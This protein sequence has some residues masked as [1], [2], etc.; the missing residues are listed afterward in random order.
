MRTRHHLRLPVLAALFATL[1]LPTG[2][3]AAPANDDFAGATPIASLPFDTT[4]ST[5]GATMETTEPR[6]TCDYVAAGASVWHRFAPEAAGVVR[7]ST[8]GSDYDTVLAVYTQFEGTFSAVACNDQAEADSDAAAVRFEATGGTTYFLQTSGH[9]AQTGLL[10]LHVEI[11]MPADPAPVIVPPV[12]CESCGFISYE[13]PSEFGYR[14]GETS[15]GIN[16]RTNTAMFLL[17]T[18]VMRVRWDDTQSPPS[19]RWEDVT[20]LISGIDT[21]DPILWTDPSTGRTFVVQLHA[22]YG[23]TIEYTDDDGETWTMGEPATVMPSF[24]HQSLGGGPSMLPVANP[25]YPNTLYYCAQSGIS[26]CARS[27]DG[28]RTWGAPLPMNV[29]L[30]GGLHGHIVVAPDGTVYVPHR[31]CGNAAAVMVSTNGG[32]TW[33]PRPVPSTLPSPSD[34]AVASDSAGRLYFVASSEGRALV[35]TTTDRGAH[36]SAPID[37]GA[38]FGIH[39]VEQPM[40]VAG[41]AG[42]A[43]VAFYG[44]REAGNDQSAGYRGVWHL[45]L[46]TTFDG[47]E[48]WVTTD[49]TPNDPVQRGCIWMGGGENPCRNLLDFQGM[50]V[51]ANGRIIIG[52]ADGCVTERCIGPDGNPL[53]SRDSRGTIARQINGPRLLDSE[54]SV[55][56]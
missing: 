19:A 21:N 35:S 50:T 26:Q 9:D 31:D 18:R 34:P 14:A 42:R 4:E 47:G 55:E 15:I 38:A 32:I 33:T 6:P 41:D 48:T 7:A 53:M 10:R 45:Y 44:A 46:S 5:A 37:V 56:S 11:E 28:A 52:Y 2:A 8:A 36:W 49:L 51:D 22:P 25:L 54:A 30:C 24:D 16:R 20:G 27:E 3:H 39:N 12:Q 13:V 1:A 29:G 40:A 17:L 43:A 23:S